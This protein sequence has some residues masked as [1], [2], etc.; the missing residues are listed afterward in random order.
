MKV[1][2]IDTEEQEELKIPKDAII[3]VRN[4]KT[5]YPIYGGFF[6][7]KI[8][9]VKAV[10]GV[11]FDLRKKETLGLVGESGCGKTTIGNT[12]LHLVPKTEG[13]IYYKG[14][15][16][17]DPLEISGI[18]KRIKHKTEKKLISEGKAILFD[19]EMRK[20]IQM[21][22]QDP[23]ASLNP[24]WKIVNIIG[25]PLKILMGMK[26]RS[27]IRRRVLELLETVSMKPEHLDR[28]PHEFS[29]GQKQRIVIA[30]ALAC[31][32]EVI[33]LDEPTSALDVSVQAQI[34]NLLKDLQKRFEL[35][36]LFITHDL[37]VVQHIADRIEVMYLGKFV[38]GGKIDEVFYNPSHP[39]TK[40][41]LSARPT[42]DPSSKVK[43]IILEGD[44]PSP[45]NPPSG[46]PFHPRCYEKNKHV[47]CSIK[48]PAKINLGGDHYIY[49]RPLAEPKK[50]YKG[51]GYIS[52]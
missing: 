3:S 35:S 51:I 31:N 22:F 30:R 2:E 18:F 29:G 28:Y 10:D 6:K 12:I 7:R 37:S 13:V 40:A 8:G 14:I 34:L 11:S 49:C 24:R 23:D 16:I 17:V 25:E 33:I 26:K 41:L 44:V 42:F 50:S 5:Y 9:D 20:K 4:L 27:K 47:D 19:K 1:L 38:E 46:C 32:P 39:Y 15:K 45:V 36:F 48:K 21:V 43:R 52:D